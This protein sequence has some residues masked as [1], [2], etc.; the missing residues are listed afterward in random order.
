MQVGGSE[1]RVKPK[2]ESQDIRTK[3]R[4]CKHID[5][6]DALTH[7]SVSGKVSS[8]TDSIVP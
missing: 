3:E 6:P 2:K 8:L 7:T 5:P 4:D 1:L